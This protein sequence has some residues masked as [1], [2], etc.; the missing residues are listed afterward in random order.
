MF[1]FKRRDGHLND[2]A[3]EPGSELTAQCDAPT[4][5]AFRDHV[6]A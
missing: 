5:K 6:L 4:K 3:R 2:V 1:S